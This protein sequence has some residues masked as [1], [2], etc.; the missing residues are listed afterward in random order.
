[1]FY[2]CSYLFIGSFLVSIEFSSIQ[3]AID[4]L[5][6]FQATDPLCFKKIQPMTPGRNVRHRPRTEL[7]SNPRSTDKTRPQRLGVLT[8]SEIVRALPLRFL[9]FRSSS[10]TRNGPSGDINP[11]KRRVDQLSTRIDYGPRIAKDL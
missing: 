10:R 6:L 3:L 4:N 11:G 7:P 2:V 9:Y 5:L 1:I 8:N